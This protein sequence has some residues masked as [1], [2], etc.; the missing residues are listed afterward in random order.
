MI[1]NNLKRAGQ[2]QTIFS[3]Q[4]DQSKQH[5]IMGYFLKLKANFLNYKI[6]PKNGHFMGYLFTTIE[7][8]TF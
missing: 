2:L 8:I 7:N 1:L 4:R 5:S 3:F 6:S